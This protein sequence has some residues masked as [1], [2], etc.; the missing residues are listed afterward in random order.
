MG[1]GKVALVTGSSRGIGRAV[2]LALA[3]AGYD[4]AVHHSES[5]E[6]AAK[7]LADV[8]ALGVNAVILQGDTGDRDV[9]ARIVNETVE[10]LGRLDVL[11]N[12]AGITRFEGILDI[13]PEI[14]DLLYNVDF[15]GMILCASA[16]AKHMVKNGVKG[17]I[18]FNTSIRSFSPHSNDCVY[19]ALKA[20][21]NRIIKSFAVDLGRY[22]IRVNGFSP[23]VTNV[24]VPRDEEQNDPFYRNT[25]RFIPLRRNGYAEDM[26]GPVA[27]LVSE[28]ASYVTGQVIPVDGGLSAVG[29]PESYNEMLNF[30]DVEEWFDPPA[31]VKFDMKDIIRPKNK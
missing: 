17:N 8:K 19:G 4:I 16:A 15:R 28:E 12:N 10:R 14:M 26:G 5:P 31:G 18:V 23:G 1:N 6:Q 9:P 24:R 21:L 30:Y 27:W 13:T 25:H 29:M 22:G 20:G 11:V 7:T 2:A 3:R